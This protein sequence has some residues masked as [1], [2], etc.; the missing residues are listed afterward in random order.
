MTAMLPLTQTKRKWDKERVVNVIVAQL[1][2]WSHSYYNC[3]IL[4]PGFQLIERT[5]PQII[6]I[7]PIGPFVTML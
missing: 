1:Y 3:T 5:D 4:V 7:V 2:F 6:L